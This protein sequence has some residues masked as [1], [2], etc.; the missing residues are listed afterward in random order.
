MTEHWDGEQW[1][2]P[3]GEIARRIPIDDIS[4]KH[5]LKRLQG[6]KDITIQQGTRALLVEEGRLRQTL[7]PGKHRIDSWWERINELRRSKEIEI[8]LVDL[9]PKTISFEYDDLRS[10]S[11]FTF[12]AAFDIDIKLD[13]PSMFY[14]SVMQDND[15]VTLDHLKE[16]LDG[17][18]ENAMQASIKD[19]SYDEIYGNASFTDN[20]EATLAEHARD[21]LNEVGVRFIRVRYFDFDDNLEEVHERRRE[22]KKDVMKE[23][24]ELDAEEERDALRDRVSQMRQQA[25]ERE[26]QE[27]IKKARAEKAVQQERQEKRKAKKDHK[28]SLKT[29]EAEGEVTRREKHWDQ[30]MEEM[31]DL[32]DLKRELDKQKIQREQDKIETREDAA[33]EVLATLEETDDDTTELAKMEKAKEMATEKLEALGAQENPELGKARQEANRDVD[34]KRLQDQKDMLNQMKD[35]MDQAMEQMGD[36]AAAKAKEKTGESDDD[37]DR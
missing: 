18:L 26:K 12:A 25:I 17:A 21:V 20:V 8:I 2:R 32:M 1:D 31:E 15:V 16:E 5:L 4:N 6:K 9:R 28:E 27:A 7:E 3:E 24:A 10:R 22:A 37:E 29:R 13:K 30:D 35:V 33:L 34:E 36:T 23:K 11:D 19:H 14:H